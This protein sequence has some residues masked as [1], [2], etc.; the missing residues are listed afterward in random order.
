PYSATLASTGGVTPITWTLATGSGPLPGGLT[1]SSG[2]AITGTPT[3][4]GTFN[5]TVQAADSGTPQ[6]KVTKAF[7][8]TIIQKLAI[9]TPAA[10]STGSVTTP[11]SLTFTSSGGTGAVTWAVASGSTLPGGLT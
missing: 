6:Q 2:G 3:A 8:I 1:L 11:Y 4:A 10:L 9:T 7:T 5:F